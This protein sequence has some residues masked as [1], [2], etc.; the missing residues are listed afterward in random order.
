MTSVSI[1]REKQIYEGGVVFLILPD[2]NGDS[3]A[4]SATPSVE[5]RTHFIAN[6]LSPLSVTDFSKGSNFQSITILG[7]GFTSVSNNVSI[8]TNTGALKLLVTNKVYR[9]TRF[10]NVWYEDA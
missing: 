7:D 5:N 1:V 10:N 2:V 9:F 4:R 6:N 3:L 8:K